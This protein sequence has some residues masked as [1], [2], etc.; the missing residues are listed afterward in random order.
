M[1]T[2]PLA[3]S[4]NTHISFDSYIKIW[5]KKIFTFSGCIF[6]D[7]NQPRNKNVPKQLP[8]LFDLWKNKFK[9]TQNVLRSI[10]KLNQIKS[11]ETNKIHTDLTKWRIS[12]WNSNSEKCVQL[13]YAAHFLTYV[14]KSISTV[15]SRI[16]TL[17]QM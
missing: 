9:R 11:E 17:F 3:V 1:C 7:E 14:A 12:Q 13:L 15:R 10:N 5:K 8:K 2:Q 16:I 4:K 6:I